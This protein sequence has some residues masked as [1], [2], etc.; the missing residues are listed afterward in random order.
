MRYGLF[1][2]TRTKQTGT[3]RPANRKQQLIDISAQ[4][5]LQH[6]YPQVSMADIARAAGVTAPS[7][8]RHFA[9]KQ[10]LLYS[11]VLAG[12]DDLAAATDAALAAADGDRQ[13]F[14]TAICSSMARRRNA[15]TLWRWTGTYLTSEQ[16]REV[17]D[18]TRV[19][20]RR[21]ADLLFTDRDLADWEQR[22]LVWTL[23]S[24]VGSLSV[25]HTRLTQAQA[26]RELTL[27]SERLVALAPSTAPG[28]RVPPHVELPDADRRTEILDAAS[29]LFS[30]RGYGPVTVDEIG[31]AVGITGPSV[32]KHFPSKA[33]ILVE[34]GRRSG[35]RLEVGV[36]TSYAAGT[37]DADR[38]SLMV[39]SYVAT[40]TSTS[41]L[42]VSFNNASALAGDPQ[43]RELIDIQRRYVARWTALM[44][45]VHGVG[46]AQAAIAV[47]AALSIVN[48][49]VRVR[50]GVERPDFPAQMAYLMR[51]VLG[52]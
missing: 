52:V 14:L 34:I 38:L 49:A 39:D 17:V 20:L 51:G 6:G 24:V 25:H 28:L 40:I 36:V 7:L 50:R 45:A 10:A 1:T 31:A 41:D 2:M 12:V 9:D 19:A 8:Y 16:N 13:R 4:L 48:D 15:S 21:W 44:V 5:F 47:H 29:A 35:A 43:A 37:D 18:G 22:Q 30:D 32:Y 3:P 26:V 27:A 33:A 42:S 46:E 11:A 23:L